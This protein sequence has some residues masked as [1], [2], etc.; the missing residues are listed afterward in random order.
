M[1]RGIS[2]MGLLGSVFLMTSTAAAATFNES[3][4]DFSGTASTPTPLAFTAGSNVVSGSVVSPGDVRDFIRFTVAP[5]QTLVALRITSYAPDN[6]GF[7]AITQG[8][9]SFNPE[10]VTAP[11]GVF[12][13]GDHVSAAAVGS[14]VLPSLAAGGASGTTFTLPLGPGEYS[15]V[16]QQTGQP[17]VNYSVEFVINGPVRAPALG[18]WGIGALCVGLAGIGASFARRRNAAI[19]GV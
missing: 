16:I 7:H 4:G 17:L 1:K 8:P 5:G 6:T 13:G 14:D 12:Y 9:V 18:A 2:G 19:L 15:Y 11:P 3:G 10:T